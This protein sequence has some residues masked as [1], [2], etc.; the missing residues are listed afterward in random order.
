M[1]QGSLRMR[2]SCPKTLCGRVRRADDAGA[3]RRA[4][5]TSL[6]QANASTATRWQV[7]KLRNTAAVRLRHYRKNVQLCRPMRRRGGPLRSVALSIAMS[8]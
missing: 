8:Q 6:N 5:S 1:P 2:L 3:Q 4:Q 7:T